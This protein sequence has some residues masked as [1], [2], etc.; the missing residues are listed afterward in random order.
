MASQDRTREFWSLVEA[1]GGTRPSG[2]LR[3]APLSSASSSEGGPAGPLSAALDSRSTFMRAVREVSGDLQRTSAKMSALTKLVKKRGVFDDVSSEV[4]RLTLSIK[5]DMHSQ[6]S[7]LDALQEYVTH[8]RHQATAAGARPGKPVPPP[9]AA[10]R[11]RGAPGGAAVE[12]AP[13]WDLLSS[14][15]GISHGDAIVGQLQGALLGFTS[16]LK[17]GGGAARWGV[18]LRADSVWEAPVFGE[19]YRV[20]RGVPPP[21]HS[22]LSPALRKA[23]AH[24]PTPPHTHTHNAAGHSP[25]AGRERQGAER[26]AGGAGRDAGPGA[27]P[28]G[29]DGS[30][31]GGAQRQRRGGAGGRRQWQRC[32]SRQ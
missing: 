11:P 10:S 14:V 25:G 30:V 12:E 15:Q 31:C 2:L 8:R 22:Q 16:N 20:R 32:S 23:H 9:P 28:G 27:A 6:S 21:S 29:D 5:A 17:V 13:G 4:E 3:A 18:P 19:H 7:R 1:C 26:P 24:P